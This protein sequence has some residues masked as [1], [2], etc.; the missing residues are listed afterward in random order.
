MVD[1]VAIPSEMNL[2]RRTYQHIQRFIYVCIEKTYSSVAPGLNYRVWNSPGFPSR[3]K[4]R[5]REIQFTVKCSSHVHTSIENENTKKRQI[6]IPNC[7]LETPKPM[8][9][10]RN[11]KLIISDEDLYGLDTHKKNIYSSIY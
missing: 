3:W 6:R 4:K 2:I 9:K 8:K 1:P 11:K 5:E 10:T 7:K